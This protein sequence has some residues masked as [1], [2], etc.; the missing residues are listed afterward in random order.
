REG[1]QC[2]TI[3]ETRFFPLSVPTFLPDQSSIRGFPSS[4]QM[5]RTSRPRSKNIS[6]K[7]AARY[8]TS[9]TEPRRRQNWQRSILRQRSFVP[10]FPR[11][12][13]RVASQRFT[14]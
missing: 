12:P 7:P 4:E 11:F 8:T 6:K 14:I 1:R 3:A 13:R 10:P 2:R 9:E 5:T